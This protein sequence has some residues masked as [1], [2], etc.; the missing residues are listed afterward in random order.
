M[1]SSEALRLLSVGGVRIE[2]IIQFQVDGR[3]VDVVDDDGSLLEALRDRLGVRSVKDGCSPQGQCGCCTVL[4]DDAPRVACVTPLRRVSGR[5]VTTVDGLTEQERRRWSHAF[6]AHGAAQCGFCTPGIVCRFVGHERKGA[7]LGRRETVDRAL[8]AHLCRCTGWQTI[9]EAAAE[10]SVDLP[11]RDLSPASQQATIETGR[12]QIVGPEVILG[13][14]GFADD[15][16]PL[17]AL[18]AVRSET[19]WVT[20]PSL[21][22]ARANM[23][24]VQGRRTSLVSSPPLELPEGDWAVALRTRWVEPAYLE[25]DASWCLPGGEAADPIAN[26]GA[27]GGKI[28]GE[29]ANAA[30]TLAREH[31]APVRALWSREDAVRYGIKRPPLAAGLHSDGSGIVRV[32]RTAGIAALIQSVLPDCEVEEVVVPGPPTSL[33]LRAAG[34]AEAEMLRTALDGKTRWVQSPSGG[35]AKADIVDGTIR[36]EVDVGEPLDWV[37]LRSYCIG[38]AH[39]GY[40]WVTSESIAVDN[41]GDVHDLTVRSFGVVS[42]SETPNIEVVSVGEGEIRPAGEAVFAAVAAATW[43]YRG[44]PVNLPTG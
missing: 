8:S 11:V 22:E 42:S 13:H 9:R 3:D 39:M 23:G 12:P 25:I 29:V 24:K 19:G 40:S 34:W 10:T 7:D 43:L 20:A 31:D 15:T 18:V 33:S 38:A 1:V 17:N 41:H 16:A 30:R 27:F 5:I 35:R 2:R 4:I 37:M 32:A 26:G 21:Q 28:G 6:V 36:V 44:C 14:G